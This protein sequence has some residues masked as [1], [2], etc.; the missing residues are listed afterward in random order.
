MR[1]RFETAKLATAI[2]FGAILAGCG[3]GGTTPV[4]S[5]VV[6]LSGFTS[7]ALTTENGKLGRY[8]GGPVDGWNCSDNPTSYCQGVK[9]S[10]TRYYAYYAY[11]TSNIQTSLYSGIFIQAPNISQDNIGTA[12]ALTGVSAANKT[13]LNFKLGQNSEW[14]RSANKNFGVMLT[15][16]TRYGADCKIKLWQV[17]TPTAAADTAY[18]INLS[19]FRITQDCGNTSF[20]VAQVLSDQTVV[21]MDFQAN[22]GDA[23]IAATGTQA[24]ES[25]N[26]SV[27]NDTNDGYTGTTMALV[28][29][30]TFN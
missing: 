6:F 12:N 11:P 25:A 22:A 26:T 23:R 14:Y 2:G 28:A 8:A 7:N 13:K 27:P 29:P 19:D 10:A 1:S 4:D 3:G 24:R 5:T 20:T 9:E 17:V 18:S 30:I 16:S 15:M 21:Q